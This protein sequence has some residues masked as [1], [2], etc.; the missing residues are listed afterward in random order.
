MKSNEMNSYQIDPQ[1]EPRYYTR[2]ERYAVAGW[3]PFRQQQHWQARGGQR[4]AAVAKVGQHR[5]TRHL[6]H[7]SV[8]VEAKQLR[9][10][11]L[12][13]FRCHRRRWGKMRVPPPPAAAA[14]FLLTAAARL[15]CTYSSWP[16]HCAG[17]VLTVGGF[18]LLLPR[19]SWNA[20]TDP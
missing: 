1:R 12:V 5:P 6:S 15:R 14:N 20:D 18:A 7:G 4:H 19:C 11:G 13:G 2:P 3:R 8:L 9:R 10:G 17:I 16:F